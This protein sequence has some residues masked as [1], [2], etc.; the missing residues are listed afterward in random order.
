MGSWIG[1]YV[2]SVVVIVY[3]SNLEYEDF[4]KRRIIE[5]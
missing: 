5:K 4:D 3:R 2:V 1:I